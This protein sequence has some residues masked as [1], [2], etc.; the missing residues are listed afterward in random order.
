MVN[1]HSVKLSIYEAVEIC[2]EKNLNFAAY[3]QPGRDHAE[4]IIQSGERIRAVSKEESFQNLKGFLIV[5]FAETAKS[6]PFLIHPD[7]YASGEL[8]RKQFDRIAEMEPVP[9]QSDDSH[10]PRQIAQQHYREQIRDILEGIEAGIFGKV[11]LSRVINIKGSYVSRLNRI[12]STL[13]DKY[14]N[15]FVYIFNTGPNLWIGATPE[16]LLSSA[17]GEINTVSLAGTRPYSEENLDVGNWNHKERLEQDY[18]S[19]YI[20]GVLRRFHA[21][22]VQSRGPY[23]KKAGNLVHLCTDFAFRSEEIRKDLGRFIKNLHPTPAVCGIPKEKS[24]EF[25]LGFEQ[26][27][28]E[29]YS[30]FLGPV[31]LDDRFSLFVNLRCMKVL[32]NN[33]SLFVGGG[34]TAD[35]APGE[36]WNETEMKGETLLSVIRELEP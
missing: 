26:H 14:P 31:G 30:G 17:N 20:S 22:D 10:I 2:L 28:R 29:Y 13:V 3:R 12:F 11:V 7:I 1:S 33:L 19:A 25:L 15:A 4:I 35:S 21:Q 24:L 8:T 18:V 34:I 32:E 9:V 23:V 36:E 5:P 27:D 16:S 6:T